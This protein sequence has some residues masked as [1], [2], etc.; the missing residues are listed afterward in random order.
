M[1]RVTFAIGD[2]RSKTV[3][4]WCSGTPEMFLVINGAWSGG[5]K[6]GR[7]VYQGRK[8][9]ASP[10]MGTDLGPGSIIWRGEVPKGM[11]YNAA[12]TWIESELHRPWWPRLKNWVR[13]LLSYRLQVKIK[14]VRADEVRAKPRDRY[15]EDPWGEIPF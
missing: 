1:A 9:W 8:E 3:A 7:V 12:I 11:G 5:L 4:L 10:D 6:N 14:V 13:K 2:P 15:E